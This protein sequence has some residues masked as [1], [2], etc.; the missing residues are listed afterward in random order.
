MVCARCISAVEAAIREI[1]AGPVNVRLGEV[2][3]RE[4][5]SSDRRQALI[6]RLNSLGFEL[7]DDRRKRQIE[8]IKSLIIQ[9]AQTPNHSRIAIS[10]LL[11]KSM[12]REYSQLSKLFSETEGITIEHFTI[13]QRIE[14]AKEWLVYDEM[15]LSQIA[16]AL[17]YSSSSH[18]SAQFR[19]VTGMTPTAF[20]QKGRHLRR[21]LDRMD[22][23]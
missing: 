2:T 16:D 17:G 21:P 9:Q 12:N 8:K 20:R 3:L 11:S 1:G 22:A 10:E 15:S 19:K 7:L 6:V 23:D 14:K 4:P 18:L 5:L 13:L